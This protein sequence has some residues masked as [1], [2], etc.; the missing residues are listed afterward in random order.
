MKSI[1]K[2]TEFLY[3]CRHCGFLCARKAIREWERSKTRTGTYGSTGTP[4]PAS[5]NDEQYNATAIS[6]VAA[7][8][9]V[10]AKIN[11]SANRFAD[12]HFHSEQPIKIVTTSGIND[13]TYTIAARG[14]SRGTL[15]LSSSDSLTTEDAATAGEVT[16]SDVT[17]EPDVTIGCALCGSLNS[18]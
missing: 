13:G 9:D 14:V 4:T 7:A 11:D 10:P 5:F 12:R 8:G 16:I 15:I 6:F 18:R 3:K 1:P 17:Y 2:T